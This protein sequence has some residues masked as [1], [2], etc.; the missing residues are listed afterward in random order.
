MVF[1]CRCFSFDDDKTIQYESRTGTK[2]TSAGKPDK[3]MVF[4]FA[5]LK[6]AT[7]NFSNAWKIGEGRHGSVYKGKFLSK[8]PLSK[9]KL[10]LNDNLSIYRFTFRWSSFTFIIIIIYV[11]FIYNR[12]YMQQVPKDW[13]VNILGEVDHPNLVKLLGYCLEDNE[14]GKTQLLL[15]YK[16]M[17]NKSVRDH[18]S[19]KSETPLSWT[20]ILKVAHDA[21]LG[22]AY[23]HEGLDFEIPYRDFGSSKIL[24][25]DEWNAMLSGLWVARIRSQ[26]GDS[27]D[28]LGTTTYAAPEYI[29]T[30]Q[31]SSMSDVWSYG[32]FLYEHITGRKPL[33]KNRP[34]NE[35]KLLEW[36]RPHVE[37]KKIE[38]VID[39][40][41][42][43]TCSMKSVEA[44]V[45][46]AGFC[47]KENPRSR[48]KMSEVLQ[49]FTGLIGIP[50]QGI[51]ATQAPQKEVVNGVPSQVTN[52]ATG[53]KSLV[54][55][56]RSS[57]LLKSWFGKEHK[58]WLAE[59]NLLGMAEHPNLVK[60]VGY[61]MEDNEKG[62]IQLFL[63]YKYM[64]KGNV[65]DHLSTK[66]ETPLSWT[67][68]LKV[69][70][71][72]ARGL[73]YLHEGMDSQ[74]IYR[75]FNSSR[76]LLDDQWNAKLSDLLDCDEFVG[77]VAYAAPEYIYTGHVSSKS[78]VWSYG[79]FLY[80]LITG[81]QPL[82]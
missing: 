35:Q 32:V 51:S 66:S 24:L 36:V 34:Q 57:K 50:S 31:V 60:L 20:T 12:N 61:Y 54:P 22:L 25:D 7:N 19:T 16:Y 75:G 3:L 9:F 67:M 40:R 8:F 77:S 63:V 4:T 64:P 30:G 68:R 37:S 23:L 78:D 15:V 13:L 48:I 43:G 26:R 39:P 28:F 38:L 49:L 2:S 53:R 27:N 47:L 42:E 55:V 58:D 5:E 46:I 65:R 11:S 74:I 10:T 33:D 17:S 59:I 81:R 62:L 18:L 71:D 79:V 69:A 14:R 29:L 1:Y 52:G 56:I 21:T 73:A 45:T 72:A 70:Q 44:L 41:L 82:D 76:L 6:V 80:E